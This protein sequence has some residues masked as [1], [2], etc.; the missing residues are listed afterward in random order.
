MTRLSPAAQRCRREYNNAY[1]ERKAQTQVFDTILTAVPEVEHA[2]ASND[3]AEYIAQL[4][5]E[6][7]SLTRRCGALSRQIRAYQEI[8]GNAILAAQEREATT[9]SVVELAEI[10]N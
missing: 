7:Q 9:V 10:D 1:W 8:I 2:E 5:R 4:E 3:P 6:V